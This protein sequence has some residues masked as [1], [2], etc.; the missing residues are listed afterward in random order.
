MKKVV[1]ENLLQSRYYGVVF[2]FMSQLGNNC[3]GAYDVREDIAM[4][5]L[6]IL[7]TKAAFDKEE[8]YLLKCRCSHFIA[9]A[10]ITTCG[11]TRTC[12]WHVIE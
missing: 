7:E 11:G 6:R 2:F 4:S 3:Y 9:A 1:S 8:I 5:L 10:L 12:T